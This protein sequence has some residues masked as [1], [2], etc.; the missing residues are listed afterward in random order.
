MK[1]TGE[2]QIHSNVTQ[3][4]T[5]LWVWQ[6]TIYEWCCFRLVSFYRALSQLSAVMGIALTVLSAV[7]SSV[8]TSRGIISTKVNLYDDAVFISAI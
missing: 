4:W 3:W 1:S 7:W 5:K 8:C 6:R 2:F